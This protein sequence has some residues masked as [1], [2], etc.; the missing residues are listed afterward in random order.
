MRKEDIATM[1]VILEQ[2]GPKLRGAVLITLDENMN[3]QVVN[4]AAVADAIFMCKSYDMFNLE[5]LSG[6]LKMEHRE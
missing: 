1:Q 3:C 4:Q 6:R 2:K 5:V